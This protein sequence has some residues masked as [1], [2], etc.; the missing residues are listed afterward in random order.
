M[1]VIKVTKNT[2]KFKTNFVFF[3]INISF[4]GLPHVLENK[5]EKENH[6]Q[7]LWWTNKW[8]MKETNLGTH[9]LA[10]INFEQKK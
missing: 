6:K 7:R 2:K 5:I 8:R 4:I 3:K 1:I 10:Q 9:A